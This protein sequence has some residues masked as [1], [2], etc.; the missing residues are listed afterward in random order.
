M[1]TQH[2]RVHMHTHTFAHTHEYMHTTALGPP[3]APLPT[4]MASGI[5]LSGTSLAPLD[6]NMVRRPLMASRTW[7]EGEG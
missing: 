3:P 5:S 7:G 6:W 1:Y 2:A 4:A